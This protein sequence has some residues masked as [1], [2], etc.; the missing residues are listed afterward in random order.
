MSNR[1]ASPVLLCLAALLLAMTCHAQ[2]RAPAPDETVAPEK[3]VVV[4]PKGAADIVKSLE[5]YPQDA[6][7][8][9]RNRAVLAEA[10]PGGNDAVVLFRTYMA[11]G[12]AAEAIGATREQ[13]ESY[14]KAVEW[15]RISHSDDMP[16]A[17]GNLGNAHMLVGNW[18]T[19]QRL[20]EESMVA[21]GTGWSGLR[22]AQ[23]TTLAR[24]NSRLGDHAAAKEAMARAESLFGQLRNTPCL[25]YTSPSP[26]D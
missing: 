21:A 20:F 18:L 7:R 4:P 6:G 19:A 13:L 9:A 17:L 3:P 26:R 22:L 5:G 23:L 24:I 15:G 8:V 12:N 16:R 14:E 1:L 25:L 2:P 10:V 11:R